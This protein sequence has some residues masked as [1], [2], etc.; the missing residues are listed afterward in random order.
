MKNVI[1]D[2]LIDTAIQREEEAYSFYTDLGKKVDDK[3][4]K[5]ALKSLAAD[6]KKHKEFLVSYKSGKAGAGAL[7]MSTVIDYQ[8]AQHVDKPDIKKNAESK[9][10]Y[11][12]A[13]HRELNSYNLYKGLADLQPAGEAKE[14]LLK[15]ANEELKHKEK[16]EYLYANTAFPQT[17]GG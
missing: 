11:L 17:E 16:V 15:M 10:I 4:A 3:T 1:L 9:D 6:E 12:I 7:K 5:D 13:A 8:I 14:M 2:K